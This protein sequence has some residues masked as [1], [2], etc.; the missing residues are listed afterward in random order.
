MQQVWWESPPLSQ[1]LPKQ[2]VLR[3][4]RTQTA[5]ASLKQPTDVGTTKLKA[6]ELLCYTVH[7]N[8]VDPFAA[9]VEDPQTYKCVFK[10]NQTTINIAVGQCW[11][12]DR[13][14]GGLFYSECGFILCCLGLVESDTACLFISLINFDFIGQIFFVWT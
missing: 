1:N 3:P 8:T 14:L 13:C 4:V 5:F 11:S 6:M 12:P 7:K 2:K 10:K 9:G